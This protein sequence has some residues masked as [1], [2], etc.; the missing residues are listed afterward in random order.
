MKIIRKGGLGMMLRMKVRTWMF[1]ICFWCIL[2]VVGTAGAA[3]PYKLGA[4]FSV[5]GRASFIGA[6]EKKTAVMLAEAINA[7]G[8]INGHPLKLIV[9]DDEGDAT[10]CKLLVKRLIK[11]DKVAAIIGPSLNVLSLAV[12]PLAQRYKI[13]LVSHATS[14]EIVWN[15]KK[16]KPYRWVFKVAQTDSMAV[17]A[18]YTHMKKKGISKIAIMTASSGFGTSGRTELI[19]LANTYGMKIVVDEKYGPKDTDMTAQLAKIKRLVP[20]PQA[21]VNWSIGHTQVVVVKNWKDLGMRNISLYQS[22]RFGSRKNIKLASGAAEGV[23]CPLG[24][25]NVAEIL[26]PD[27]PQKRVTM[28]YLRM[29]TTK[30]YEPI[31][32]FGGH[33]W[34]AMNLLVDAMRVAGT[35]KKAIRQYLENKKGFVG[36]HGVFNFTPMDHNGLTKKAFN[37]VVVK[38]GDWV[39]AR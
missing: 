24:A 13:P 35:K 30:Y 3:K 34:D 36:Q 7:K 25:V 14:Y 12:A 15:K 38:N 1:I 27:H 28:E 6:P 29:Y 23:Y 17:E 22:Y 2:V 31:S 19:R 16:K 10:K 33:A 4:V 20:H 18:I 11:K 9:Y 21:I 32:S 37:I 5:T 26:P 39:L 8:G